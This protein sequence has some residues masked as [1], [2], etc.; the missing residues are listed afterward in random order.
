MKQ[1]LDSEKVNCKTATLTWHSREAGLDGP[2]PWPYE[3]ILM[4]CWNSPKKA[5]IFTVGCTNISGSYQM[6]VQ[7]HWV[8]VQAGTKVI[9]SVSEGT[10]S[11][12]SWNGYR[13]ITRAFLAPCLNSSP[14]FLRHL[15]PLGVQSPL[16][17][18]S[19]FTPHLL[20]RK[21]TISFSFCSGS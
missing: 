6:K 7:I 2:S 15:L 12:K 4:F 13:A 11:T 18:I 16:N 17:C 10:I 1:R 5:L 21:N 14:F 19:P 8:S 9:F 20:P 3:S